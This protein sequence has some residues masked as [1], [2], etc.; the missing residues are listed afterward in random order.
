M[1]PLPSLSIFLFLL[2]DA[3]HH[4]QSTRKHHIYYQTHHTMCK[5]AESH[6][7]RSSSSSFGGD[8]L[9]R[10]KN[11]EHVMGSDLSLFEPLHVDIGTPGANTVILTPSKITIEHSGGG[12]GAAGGGSSASAVGESSGTGTGGA[13]LNGDCPSNHNAAFESSPIHWN[14]SRSYADVS[15]SK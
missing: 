14:Y 15:V 2:Y 8:S 4:G 7:R 12:G 1:V 10:R 6:R 11:A 13:P 5:R 3:A 9:R